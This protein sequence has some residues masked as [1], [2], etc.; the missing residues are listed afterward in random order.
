MRRKR[1]RR[2][3]RLA[4]GTSGRGRGVGRAS[5]AGHAGP[6][7]GER[8]H[9]WN[10][11]VGRYL[12]RGSGH[13]KFVDCPRP[14]PAPF[15]GFRR[16]IGALSWGERRAP[17]TRTSGAQENERARDM[18]NLRIALVP[19]AAPFAGLPAADW[20]FALGWTSRRA[21]ASTSVLSWFVYTGRS[22]VARIGAV[23][24]SKG[25]SETHR[26]LV[27]LGRGAGSAADG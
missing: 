14:R 8:W 21:K 2:I 25:V 18:R 20:R 6:C 15:A 27:E 26:T 16:R 12:Q 5:V 7:A 9:T 19:G 3:S 1:K 22:L 23:I 4:V 10:Q 13:A 17:R 11:R 24:S